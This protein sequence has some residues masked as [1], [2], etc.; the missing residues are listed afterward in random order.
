MG[1]LWDSSCKDCGEN[2]RCHH[3]ARRCWS[4]VLLDRYDVFWLLRLRKPDTAIIFIMH[5]NSTI[6][7]KQLLVRYDI[8]LHLPCITNDHNLTGQDSYS[9][10]D[11]I[12]QLVSGIHIWFFC[13]ASWWRHQIETFSVLLA[14]CVGNSPVT[15]EFPSH[16]PVTWSFDVFFDYPSTKDWV[17][18]RNAGDLRC[19]RAHYDVIVRFRHQIDG[20]MQERRNSIANTLELRLPCNNPSKW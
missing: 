3:G 8:H 12:Q 4:V 18:K 9:C 20:L 19:H 16:R 1:E 17:N 5:R 2:L 7:A 10:Y 6:S 13:G 11:S 14:L 15:R